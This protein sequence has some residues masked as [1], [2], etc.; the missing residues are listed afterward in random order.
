MV[1]G[2]L[3]KLRRFFHDEEEAREPC[4]ALALSGG[5]A[6]AS[7]Q[8]GVLKYIAEAF[9]EARFP[10]LTGVSAGAINAAHLANDP[11][12]FSVA[13]DDLVSC[14]E[15]LRAENVY[16][17]ES[18]IKFFWRALQ[19]AEARGHRH[20]WVDTTPLREFLMHKLHLEDGRLTHVA[21]RLERGHLKAVAII[22]T[23]YAT[24][25]TVVWVQGCNIQAWERPNR[26]AVQT[27]LT[28]DHVMAS[29]SLPFL[30]PAVRIGDAWYGDGGIR[31]SAPLAPAIHLGA[32]GILA[33][34]TRYNRT[35]READEPN[36]VGYPPA[37]QIIGLLMNA[38]FLDT[39]DQDAAMLERINRMLEMLPEKKRMGMRPIRFLLLRPSVDLGKLSREFEPQLHGVLKLLARVFSSDR[40]KSPDWLSMLLFDR[41]YTA[42]LME[43]GYEDAVRQHH[44]I[45]AFLE[46]TTRSRAA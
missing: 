39:L 36:V 8:V 20:G 4:M 31:L 23:S 22:T 41:G 10:V 28:I 46:S 18:S 15:E 37:A 38:I 44:R 19:D 16:Q 6:R 24:G 27:E 9:P 42:R 2:T 40:T 12:P 7:Y 21:E 26:V 29:S 3:Q 1:R 30:F 13:L 5:G 33:I 32:D 35:R 17:S 45:A 14:W 25:Q 43:I 34:S 11:N